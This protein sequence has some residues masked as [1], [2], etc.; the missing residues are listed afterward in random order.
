MRRSYRLRELELRLE[1]HELQVMSTRAAEGGSVECAEPFFASDDGTVDRR[2]VSGDYGATPY[3]CRHDS[4]AQQELLPPSKTSLRECT[5]RGSSM[6][7]SSRDGA[8]PGKKSDDLQHDDGGAGH[9]PEKS[10]KDLD[11]ELDN[12][13]RDSFPSSDPPLALNRPRLSRPVTQNKP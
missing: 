13:L 12:A 8:Q 7:P 3:E 10:K 5:N 9:A 4:T 6:S 11:R 1:R 2:C